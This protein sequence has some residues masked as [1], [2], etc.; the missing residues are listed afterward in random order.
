MSD[1][2]TQIF[3]SGST[4]YFTASLFFPEPIKSRVF[5]LYAFVRTADNFVDQVPQDS[6]GFYD[7][8][9]DYTLARGGESVNN[10]VVSGFVQLQHEVGIRDEWVDAF[11]LAMEAD[12]YKQ[13][14]R[15]IDELELYMYG[16]AEVI[17]LML[18]QCM[19]LD[20]SSHQAARMLGR[21]M[22]YANFLRDVAEDRQ[23]GRQYIPS[24]VLEEFALSE[25]SPDS[26]HQ[27]LAGLYDQEI[28]RYH[29]WNELARAGFCYLPLAV[30]IPVRAASEMYS[31]T[32]SQIAK[33]PQIVWQ[34]KVKPSKRQVVRQVLKVAIQEV[35]GAF[36]KE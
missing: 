28:A 4:T 16:S 30:R 8:W 20:A 5:T 35:W 10:E 36:P 25:L 34:R 9:T 33:D 26:D 24:Q 18:V 27:Q 14:Y 2:T 3:Q 22:Q 15:T 32:L 17:G 1:T 29:R 12:L 23:F 19:R 7:F 11:F 31:W 13:T 6:Q 21:A